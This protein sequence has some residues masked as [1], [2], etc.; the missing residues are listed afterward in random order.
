MRYG[1]DLVPHVSIA[2]RL[3][4]EQPVAQGAPKVQGPRKPGLGSARNV[5]KV[6][7][8]FTQQIIQA[9]P[10]LNITVE[11]FNLLHRGRDLKISGDYWDGTRNQRVE[12]VVPSL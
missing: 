3:R 8:P 2:T 6:T 1:Y 4:K 10:C 7:I 12:T 9:L 5:K 11:D